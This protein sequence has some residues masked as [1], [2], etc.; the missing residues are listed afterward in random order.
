MPRGRCSAAYTARCYARPLLTRSRQGCP[1]EGAM[2][3]HGALPFPDAAHAR[4]GRR[5]GGAGRLVRHVRKVRGARRHRAPH[6]RGQ[7]QPVTRLPAQRRARRR[8][9][10]LPRQRQCAY[11]GAA[12]QALVPQPRSWPARCRPSAR[13]KA[14]SGPLA[15]CG[16]CTPGQVWCLLALMPG[17]PDRCVRMHSCSLQVPSA[18]CC[19]RSRKHLGWGGQSFRRSDERL[20][21]E[22]ALAVSACMCR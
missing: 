19:G 6:Q 1:A 3:V 20:Q 22:Q 9:R 11:P 14:G 15:P 17:R 8:P 5:R 7:Q 12:L 10:A 21:A 18:R 13:P 4:A 2:L 16:R